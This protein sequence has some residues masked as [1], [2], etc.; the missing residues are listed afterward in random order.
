MNN[1]L[2]NTTNLE[3]NVGSEGVG[4]LS[5]SARVLLAQEMRVPEVIHQVRVVPETTTPS[6]NFRK[7]NHK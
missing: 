2:S 4:E 3:V 5:V 1:E 6:N 7:E